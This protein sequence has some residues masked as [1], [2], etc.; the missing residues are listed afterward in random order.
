MSALL[1][2]AAV[3]SCYWGFNSRVHTLSYWYFYY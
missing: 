2:V 1:S 3:Y